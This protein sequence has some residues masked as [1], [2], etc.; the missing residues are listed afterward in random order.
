M[1]FFKIFTLNFGLLIES[2]PLTEL[3]NPL[4]SFIGVCISAILL[5]ATIDSLNEQ[6][7]PFISFS[8]EPIKKVDSLYIVIRNTGNRTANNVRITTKPILTSIFSQKRDAPLILSKDGEIVLSGISPNQTIKSFFDSCLW[9]YGERKDKV[10]DEIVAS[11]SYEYRRRKFA[12]NTTI[13][14]SYLKNISTIV[15]VDDIDTNIMKIAD[16]IEFIDKNIKSF[17]DAYK[18]HK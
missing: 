10:N 15:S 2:L 6:N 7:W 11:I 18:E 8:I 4:L 13:N 17:C 12:E 5:K 9:R 16:S 3:I 14:L 1:D